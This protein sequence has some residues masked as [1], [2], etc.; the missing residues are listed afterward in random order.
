MLAIIF[1]GGVGTVGAQEACAD[2][3]LKD[4]SNDPP[5]L[6]RPSIDGPPLDDELETGVREAFLKAKKAFHE[7]RQ[8]INAIQKGDTAPTEDVP[9]FFDDADD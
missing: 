4:P 9:S 2:G 5:E 3:C 8:N 1:S 7:A 6:N